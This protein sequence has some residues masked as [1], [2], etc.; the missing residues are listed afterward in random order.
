[1]LK[2]ITIENYA[3]IRSLSLE[4][5]EGLTVITGETGAGKSVLLGALSLILGSRADTQV[6]QDKSE[7]CIVEGSFRI[8]GYALEPFF[9]ENELD[10]DPLS[11]LRREILPGGRSRAFIN[12]TPV[13][14]SQ[15]KSLGDKLVNIHSQH[16]TITLN[17]SD[18]QLAVVDNYAGT[19]PEIARYKETYTEYNRL[20]T[21]LKS[22]QEQEEKSRADLDYYSFQLDELTKANLKEGELEELEAE[23]KVL[24]HAG[25]IKGTLLEAGNLLRDGDQNIS[26]SVSELIYKISK[27][28]GYSPELEEIHDRLQAAL[29]DLSDIAREIGNM[30]EKI[31]LDPGRIE[32]INLR[33]DLIYHLQYKHHVKS[34]A[35]LIRLR[36]E[37]E[38]KINNIT[39]LGEQIIQIT[40][41]LEQKR[42]SLQDQSASLTGKRKKSF[43]S[44]EKAVL[45]STQKLGM[46]HSRFEIGHQELPEFG[47]DGRDLVRFLFNANKGGTLA[48]IHK[49][50]SGGELS[51]LMLSVKS[52]ISIKNLL[53]TI[54][55]DEIDSG[56]SGPIADKMGS[57]LRTMSE[58]MQ[59]IVITHLPQIAGKG[60]RHF[61]VFKETGAEST[62]TH[63]IPLDTDNRVEEIARMLSGEK[64][65]ESA[66]ETARQLLNI[67]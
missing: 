47:P 60:H 15:L 32:E 40:K 52:L 61:K 20:K 34:D 1:M 44:I 43:L 42:K 16:E 19:A 2:Q 24:E 46:P 51:R 33:L 30:E 25:E 11:I 36:S 7:K 3:L 12:D 18:F 55:F 41:E 8:E 4:F 49:I 39:F 22:L 9:L 6:L 10:Y 56:V 65:T 58:N 14:L 26:G 64:V 48:E 31:N 67:T 35:D 27:I 63:I 50:A 53:P 57:I 21:Q 13:S 17:N 59:V 38:D 23:Q 28:R 62:F 54:I 45:S 29:I 5:G 37:F 66:T